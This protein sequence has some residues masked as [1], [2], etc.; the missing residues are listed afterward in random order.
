MTADASDDSRFRFKFDIGDQGADK[1]A[2]PD[3]SF[4]WPYDFFSMVELV[5]MDADITWKP[6]SDFDQEQDVLE[7]VGMNPAKAIQ[8]G[9]VKNNAKVE[10]EPLAPAEA[11]NKNLMNDKLPGGSPGGGIPGGPPGGGPGGNGGNPI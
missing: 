9:P 2:V 5:Q 8:P 3:Y 4:N 10:K 11:F 1:G 7:A 6:G